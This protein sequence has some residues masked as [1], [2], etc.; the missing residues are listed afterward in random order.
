MNPDS[1]LVPGPNPAD[2]AAGGLH[3]PAVAAGPA[4]ADIR[5]PESAAATAGVDRLLAP[6]FRR[7]AAQAD[8]LLDL[9]RHL[10][11]RDQPGSC[12][13]LYFQLVA[14]VP[15]W[16]HVELADLRDHLEHFI[17][18]QI[19]L[20]RSR[21]RFLTCLGLKRTG[22]FNDYCQLVMREAARQ[23]RDCPELEL[24]FGWSPE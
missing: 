3:S 10:I 23:Y 2:R 7:F 5:T 13:R 20:E 9:R 22:T 24:S 17:R 15:A 11:E 14:Q 19:V 1:S 12:V 8:L 21:E 18:L 4:A 6:L 16:R